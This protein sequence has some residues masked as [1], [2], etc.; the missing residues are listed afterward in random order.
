MLREVEAIADRVSAKLARGG[1]WGPFSVRA[2]GVVV[3]CAWSG[4]RHHRGDAERALVEALADTS[5]EAQ[6]MPGFGVVVSERAPRA[7]DHEQCTLNEEPDESA[8]RECELYEFID[9]AAE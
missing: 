4:D 5:F 9:D 2:E 6:R 7:F 8:E 3:F 1:Q